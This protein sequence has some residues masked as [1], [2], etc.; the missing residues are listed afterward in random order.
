MRFF[1]LG[2]YRRAIIASAAVAVLAA[3]AQVTLLSTDASAGML[4]GATVLSG[5]YVAMGDSFAAGDLIPESPV[6]SPAGCLRSSRNYSADVAARIG[7]T[8]YVDVACTGATTQDISQPQQVLLGSNPPQLDA[9]S[10]G[11]SLVTLSIGGNDMGFVSVLETCGVLSLTDVLGDPC[12]RHYTAGGADKLKAAINATAPKVAAVLQ[13]IHARAPHALVLLVGYPDILP[14]TG[15]GCFPLAPFARG[16]VPYLRGVEKGLNQ[17]LATTALAN[18]AT[19]VDAYTATIGHDICQPSGVKDVE[20]LIPTSP[21][22]PFHPN[23]RGEQAMADQV[24]ATLAGE[25][26]RGAAPRR[27]ARAQRR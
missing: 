20:G 16:D 4:R 5:T 17:M 9:L 12:E 15:H 22:V 23:Q 25:R 8:G 3:Q 7:V 11:D 24:L 19:F 21:V 14:D 18:G 27:S 10:A 13:D 26:A 6:G 1:S 2:S